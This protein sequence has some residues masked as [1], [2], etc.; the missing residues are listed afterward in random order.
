M[1]F[2][3]RYITNARANYPEEELQDTIGYYQVL[4]WLLPCVVF[5]LVLGIL[6]MTVN[7]EAS[8]ILG[9][10]LSGQPCFQ[11]S[12]LPYWIRVHMLQEERTTL[13]REYN[14]ELKQHILQ[15]SLHNILVGLKTNG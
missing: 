15:I 10:Y 4:T 8:G 3:G 14:H 7:N 11:A 1:C 9:Y 2:L 5:L 13:N 6:A 12:I